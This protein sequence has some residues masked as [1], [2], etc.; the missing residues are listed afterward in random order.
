MFESQYF[1][2]FIMKIPYIISISL[3]SKPTKIIK[4]L[5]DLGSRYIHFFAQLMR[6]NPINPFFEQF[7]QIS[8]ISWKTLD[9]CR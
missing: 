2:N 6:R 8:I 7:T 3:L 4:I 5:P 9:Y 1:P